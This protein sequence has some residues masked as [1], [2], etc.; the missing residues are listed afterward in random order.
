[1][2]AV[3]KQTEFSRITLSITSRVVRLIVGGIFIG[4][5][6]G[7]DGQ[8]GYLTLLPLLAIYPILTGIFG[9]DPLDYLAGNWKGG[10]EGECFSPSNRIALVGLGA[11]AIAVMMLSPENVGIRAFLA[12]VSV[13][14]IMAGLFGEDLISVSLGLRS[15]QQEQEVMDGSHPEHSIRLVHSV[16]IA[17]IRQYKFGRGAGPKAA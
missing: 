11:L 8:L 2:E 14:P 6:M 15:T 13:Y 17:G 12:L 16:R 4:T 5:V 10:F 1:M 9:E 3:I 7:S